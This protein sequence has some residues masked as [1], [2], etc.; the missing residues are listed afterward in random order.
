MRVAAARRRM[1][2]ILLPVLVVVLLVGLAEVWFRIEYGF[3]QWRPPDASDF[4]SYPYTDPDQHSRTYRNIARMSYDP[5]LG[6]LP[7]ANTTE[8]GYHTNGQHFRYDDELPEAKE[9]R[10]IRVFVTGGSTAWGAG[11]RQDQCYAVLLERRLAAHPDLQGFRVRV[12]PAA[13]GAYVTTQERI[14]TYNHLLD[15]A[16][17]VLVMF[18]GA[19]D[20]YEGYRGNRLLRN[21]DFMHIREALARSPVSPV[22]PGTDPAA[23]AEWDPPVWNDYPS[24]VLYRIARIIY[25]ARHKDASSEDA[26]RASFPPERTILETLRNVHA[27]LD[28][29]RRYDIDFLFYLQP[30]LAATAK[31]LADWEVQRLEESERS[32]PEWPRYVREAY[33]RFRQRLAEDALR[34]GY[35]FVDADAAIAQEREAVFVDDFHLGDRGNRLVAEHLYE[36]IIDLVIARARSR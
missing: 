8:K 2:V 33:P 28:V 24:K 25:E 23:M 18:T 12:I 5:F 15:Y 9:E 17:D 11:V 10:E 36:A 30:Y 20:V 35:R 1:F 6:Y 16:P 31:T 4:E 22:E 26:A 34:E 7:T 27:V 32:S 19:N 3:Y 29:T 14:L 13:V 21:Q